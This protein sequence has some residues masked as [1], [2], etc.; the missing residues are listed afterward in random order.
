MG[1]NGLPRP[2]RR[3]P[4]GAGTLTQL[5]TAPVR[6]PQEP[7]PRGPWIFGRFLA[8][9]LV[10]LVVVAGGATAGWLFRSQTLG[11]DTKQVLTTV[12]PAVVRVLS[13]TCGGT[14]EASGVLLDNGRVLTAA[15]AV[16][17][18]LATVV[19]TPDGRIR[20]ANLI[21]TSEDGVAVLQPIGLAT[22]NSAKVAPGDPDPKA[23]RALI[24]YTMA[25]KQVANPIGSVAD[26]TALSTVM[27]A[28]K[29]GG[30]VVDKAGQVIGLVVGDTVQASTIVPFGKL[31][32]YAATPPV[33]VTPEAGGSCTN[34]RGSQT[35]IAP[36]LQVARTPLGVEVQKLFASYLTLENKRDFRSVQA[37]YSPR[38]AK[39]LTVTRD[40]HSHATTYF[41]GPKLTEVS[42]SADGG[43]YA[44]L[45]FN[46]LFSPTASGADGRNCNRL[47]Y[48]YHL[49]RQA[50]KLVLD[51]AKSMT[52]PPASCDTD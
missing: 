29:L 9:F 17:R 7:P 33:G 11:I 49:I 31:Q 38:L 13:T 27:N 22:G 6:A 5:Q 45:T 42:P 43:A 23:Q 28:S 3:I 19:V 20:R 15:S 1:E 34:S 24:G 32:G 18:P 47:D 2:P 37:L 21:G 48:R 10:L 39:T 16:E 30:P 14:G 52:N 12:G 44:R 35:P 40:A 26:P 50:G 46:A 51:E 8:G 4:A 41:F 25:G 36:E